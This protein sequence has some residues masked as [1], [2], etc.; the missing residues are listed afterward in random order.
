[1][2]CTSVPALIP[3][4]Q[5]PPDTCWCMM[6]ACATV[7]EVGKVEAGRSESRFG[8]LTRVLVSFDRLMLLR[9]QAVLHTYI[10][11]CASYWIQTL[12]EALC[13]VSGV[14]LSSN[15]SHSLYNNPVELTNR[16]IQKTFPSPP[17]L[18]PGSHS[19]GAAVSLLS[20][21]NK[22]AYDAR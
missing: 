2:T 20:T 15:N 5:I 13:P 8:Q 7:S 18:R 11:S 3:G 6:P 12:L 9:C 4:F 10:H 22:L 1:M 19:T 21:N 14:C 17:H 16:A